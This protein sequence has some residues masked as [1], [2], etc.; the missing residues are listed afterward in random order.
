ME[1]KIK[2]KFLGEINEIVERMYQESL[3]DIKEGFDSELL[4]I[5]ESLLESIENGL[6]AYSKFEE[7]GKVGGLNY[8]YLSFLRASFLADISNYRLDYYDS[9]N[10]VS[11][12]ECSEMWNFDYIFKYFEN[13]KFEIQKKLEKQTRVQAYETDTI[14]F[15]KAEF[16]KN[17]A[18]KKIDVVLRCILQRDGER[19]LGGRIVKFYRGDFFDRVSFMFQWDQDH[20]LEPD[21]EYHSI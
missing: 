19:L 4:N 5:A 2:E 10:R 17:L 8:I 12:I 3:L 20:I 14:V 13:I 9:N 11:L 1:D 7:E 21:V 6:A 16:Y 18:D 15:E